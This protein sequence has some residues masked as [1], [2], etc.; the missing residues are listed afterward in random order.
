MMQ[1]PFSKHGH[2]SMTDDCRPRSKHVSLHKALCIYNEAPSPVAHMDDDDMSSVC[3]PNGHERSVSSSS[4]GCV[5]RRNETGCRRGK[6]P[7][8]RT[9]I[10]AARSE[11]SEAAP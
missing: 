11:S 2:N 1:A 8:I 6:I 7:D 9:P 10:D 4:R 5:P 3:G